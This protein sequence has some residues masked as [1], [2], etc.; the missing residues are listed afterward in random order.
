VIAVIGLYVPAIF[1]QSLGDLHGD[2]VR[3]LSDGVA[4]IFIIIYALSLVFFFGHPQEGEGAVIA[5]ELATWS[6]LRATVV[7]LATAGVIAWVSEILVHSLE[8]TIEDW[9]ISE[10]FAGVILIPIVGNIAEHLVGVQL[11]WRN[12]I[13][14]SLVVSLG[15]SLQVALFVAPV[16]VFLSHFVGTPMDLVFTPL[17]TATVALSVVLVSLVA[18]DGESN[19]LE[20]AQ[21]LSVYIIIAL[22]FFFFP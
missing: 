2:E 3:R 13:E 7:L 21:L 11:A 14:F 18:L 8:P 16:L 17:E 4:V 19:W 9:G 15:S 1:G 12:K 10:I 5:E 6:P 22:A 20:G